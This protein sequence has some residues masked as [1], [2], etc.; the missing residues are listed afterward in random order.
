MS[1][2]DDKK[3]FDMIDRSVKG[4]DP[5]GTAAFFLARGADPFLQYN[6]LKNDWGSSLVERVGGTVLPRGPPLITNTPLDQVGLSPYRSILLGMVR[7]PM[8]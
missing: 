8:D 7:I 4:N 6:I 2:S 1:A 5:L 3:K